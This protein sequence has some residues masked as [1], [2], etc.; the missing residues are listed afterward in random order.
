MFHVY[1]PPPHTHAQTHI[2]ARMHT[3]THMHIH[4]HAR[5]HKHT[6]TQSI[7]H[8]RLLPHTFQTRHPLS[9]VSCTNVPASSSLS[10]HHIKCLWLSCVC[11][12]P[13]DWR[14]QWVH[15]A[16]ITPLACPYLHSFG[17]RSKR[18][19]ET[20]ASSSDRPATCATNTTAA[21]HLQP[22]LPMAASVDEDWLNFLSHPTWLLTLHIPAT[23]EVYHYRRVVGGSAQQELT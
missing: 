12:S 13:P 15:L 3:Q 9:L 22:L 7:F 21:C 19:T 2:H 23:M 16:Q 6:H 14:F 17:V 1:S 4:R 8:T 10:S 18:E 5:T 11:F 20:I